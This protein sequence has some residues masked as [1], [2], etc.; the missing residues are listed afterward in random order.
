KIQLICT[1]YICKNMHQKT[2][3]AINGFGRI[4]RSLF[5]LLLDHPQVEIV[6]INDLAD[7][8]T[9]SHL[10]KYDSI[11]GVLNKTVSF[12]EKSIIVEGKS[13]PMIHQKDINQLS[14]HDFEVDIVVECTGKFKSRKELEKHLKA[15]A[16]KILLSVPP[17]E[18][19]IKTLVLG[20]ND[21][22]LQKER[23]EEHTSEL[24]SR[25]DLVC[26]LLLEKKK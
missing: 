14:W 26:R 23:S 13:Y 2:R 18:D 11:H 6:V 1:N 16:R 9:M 21:E 8:K 5:R 20:V 24:Q 10:L 22:I 15:G 4:G 25:F 7:S 3:S 17:T 19:S 12:D